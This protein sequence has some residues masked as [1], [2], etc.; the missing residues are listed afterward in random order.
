MI[1]SKR[2]GKEELRGQSGYGRAFP[3][4]ESKGYCSSLLMGGCGCSRPG[5]FWKIFVRVFLG[6]SGAPRSGVGVC[7]VWGGLGGGLFFAEA[8]FFCT[9]QPRVLFQGQDK[10]SFSHVGPICCGPL[11]DGSGVF[12][13]L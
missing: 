10:L 1:L 2:S 8:F 3:R 11:A 12:R 5:G 4:E 9:S 13:P 6:G 7:F